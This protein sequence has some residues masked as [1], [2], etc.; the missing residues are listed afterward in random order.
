MKAGVLYKKMQIPFK[1]ESPNSL[2][3]SLKET[4]YCIKSFISNVTKLECA[5]YNINELC[6]ILILNVCLLNPSLPSS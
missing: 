5:L 3:K 4:Q 2:G 1:F 6:T